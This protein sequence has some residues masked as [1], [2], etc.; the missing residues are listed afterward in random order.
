MLGYQSFIFT[1]AK[2]GQGRRLALFWQIGPGAIIIII[3]DSKNLTI[4]NT[5]IINN[6]IVT[7]MIIVIAIKAEAVRVK[8][9]QAALRPIRRGGRAV[10]AGW[11]IVSD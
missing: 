2:A 3:I 5:I 8:G 6:I 10:E 11:R 7:L 1:K 9:W 4:T